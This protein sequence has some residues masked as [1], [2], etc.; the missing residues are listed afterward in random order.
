MIGLGIWEAT[1]DTLFFK[2]TGRVEIYD[3]NGSYGF[4]G[5]VRGFDLSKIETVSVKEEGNVIDAVVSVPVLPGA[6]IAL[7]AEIDGDSLTGYAVLPI[8]GKVKI[9]DGHRIK[10][11][12]QASGEDK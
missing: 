11:N 3:D 7:H 9:K 4:R 6:E 5:S 2:E 8:I 12:G 10:E 1:V